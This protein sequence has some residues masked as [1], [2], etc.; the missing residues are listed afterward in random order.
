MTGRKASAKAKAR[1]TA[2]TTTAT[3]AT[4]AAASAGV[5]AE[6]WV[7]RGHWQGNFFC[8]PGLKW[9]SCDAENGGALKGGRRCD[10]HRGGYILCDASFPYA[11]FCWRFYF[12]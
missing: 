11:G 4:T 1:A 7:R 9:I 12:R 10:P 6:S 2:A 5:I 8:D 3:A